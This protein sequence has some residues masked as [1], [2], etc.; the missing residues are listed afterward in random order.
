M[1]IRAWA[2]MPVWN[3]EQR[4]E[5]EMIDAEILPSAFLKMKVNFPITVEAHCKEVRLKAM[6]GNHRAIRIFFDGDNFYDLDC[7]IEAIEG[8]L[9]AAFGKPINLMT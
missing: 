1:R 3:Y 8:V 7:K 9:E 6:D 5:A 2:F 4:K